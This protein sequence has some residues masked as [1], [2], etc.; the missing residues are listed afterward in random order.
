[1]LF[2][3]YYF[4]MERTMGKSFEEKR[5]TELTRGI[6]FWEGKLVTFI[7]QTFRIKLVVEWCEAI[8]KHSLLEVLEKGEKK[9]MES[10]LYV[11]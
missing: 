6:P 7:W 11:I 9:V 10:F 3:L 4:R 8:K 2:I 1:M 5:V